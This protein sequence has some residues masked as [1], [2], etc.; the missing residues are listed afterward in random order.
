MGHATLFSI[1]MA[2]VKII[3]HFSACKRVLEDT[4][5]EN[6]LHM[7]NKLF[8]LVLQD[9]LILRGRRRFFRAKEEI[10]KT[11][12][13]RKGE[14]TPSTLCVFLSRGLHARTQ[15]LVRS[16]GRDVIETAPSLGQRGPGPA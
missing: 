10:S 1:F 6:D 5:K 7:C 8:S 15:Y 16:M 12:E 11:R 3:Y 14:E 4:C 9:S 2:K 13:G